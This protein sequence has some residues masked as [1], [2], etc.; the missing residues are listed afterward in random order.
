VG[1]RQS[2]V[3]YS[4]NLFVGSKEIFMLKQLNS[5]ILGMLLICG[6]CIRLGAQQTEQVPEAPVP[7]AVIEAKTAFVSNGGQEG[8]FQMVRDSWY[9][10]GPNRAY[11]QFYAAMKAWGH[12]KLV[13]SPAEADVV[14]EISFDNRESDVS[15][16]K[17]VFIEPKTHVTLW[18]LTRNIEPAGM[19]KNREKN[20]DI[21][22]SAL[23]NDLKTVASSPAAAG[24]N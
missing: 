9:S 24:Q 12:F 10:G 22:M 13:P 5:I 18:T 16:F 8:N 7:P 4:V 15:Q 2:L 17:V 6:S 20:Y 3:Q 14:F 1:P 21:A 23:V 19:A 11:N